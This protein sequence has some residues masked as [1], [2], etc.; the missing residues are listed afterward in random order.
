VDGISVS[1]GDASAL[2]KAIDKAADMNVPVMT[3]DSDAP[4]SKRK[5]FYGTDDI[6]CGELL[7]KH[8]GELIKKGKVVIQTGV[9][10][11]PNLE[12]R[13]KGVKDY[14]AKH[15]PDIQV[16][17]VLFCNDDVKKAVDDIAAYTSAHPDIAGWCIVGGWPL[18][19][20]DALAPIDPAKT[21]VVCVDALPAMWPYLESGKCQVL[22]GQNLWGWGEQSV[23]IL[24]AMVDGKPVE[25]GAG[26]VIKAPLDVVTK[27]NLAEYKKKWNE[28]FGK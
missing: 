28:R 2:K 21:K 17:D 26:G 25:A 19:G 13:V 24:K 4:Q 5:Y 7:A 15:Y 27:D 10:G 22:L 20:K 8:M 23:K 1:C 11:A 16:T 18:F 3:F 14:F 12:L 9:A 6:E